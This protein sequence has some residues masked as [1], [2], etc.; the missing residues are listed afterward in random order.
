MKRN[1]YKIALVAVMVIMQAQNIQ[2]TPLCNAQSKEVKSECVQTDGSRS[3]EAKVPYYT[4]D[5]SSQDAWYQTSISSDSE[6]IDM[7]YIVSTDVIASRDSSGATQYRAC[8]SSDERKAIGEELA[9][10]D[11]NICKGDFNYIAPYYHQYTFETIALPTA[12]FQTVYQTVKSEVCDAFDYYMANVNKGRRFALVGFSQGGMLVLDLLR[13]MT[14]QQYS[15]MVAAYAIG[16]RIS[17]EDLKSTHIIPAT[18]ETTSGVTVSFNSVLSEKG[19]WGFVGGD[20]ATGINPVNWRTDATPA[21][22]TYRGKEHKV[23]L[24]QSNWQLMVQTDEATADSY[25]TFNG[26]PA[27]ESVNVNRDCLHHWDLLFYTSYI[28]DNILKRAGK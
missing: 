8:L 26:N 25:R 5:W 28:H 1:F 19:L 23:W 18:D 13:H 7:I 22:F 4:T 21:T 11:T 14:D 24:D 17:S 16:Y 6:K 2:A 27:F 12:Q 15:Q 20:A 10:V 3:D 9:Y